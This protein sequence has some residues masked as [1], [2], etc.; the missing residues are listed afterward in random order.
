L[1]AYNAGAHNVARWRTRYGRLPEDEFIEC[2][3]FGETRDYV[4]KILAWYDI[5]SL[6][7]PA[8]PAVE[9]YPEER[10]EVPPLPALPEL[11]PRGVVVATR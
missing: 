4:K 11:A 10:L 6:L 1:A 3:P 5:Y 9:P 2:I 7:Y 8:S